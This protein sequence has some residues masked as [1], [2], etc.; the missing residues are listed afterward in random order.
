[1]MRIIAPIDPSTIASVDC[2]TGERLDEDATVGDA[3]GEDDVGVGGLKE[4]AEVISADSTT[5]GS[6]E[7]AQ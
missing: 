7:Y 6:S 3:D 5:G 4:G 2:W 1:M